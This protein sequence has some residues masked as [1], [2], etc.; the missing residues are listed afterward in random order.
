MALIAVRGAFAFAFF[1]FSLLAVAAESENPGVEIKPCDEP[2]KTTGFLPFGRTALSEGSSSFSFNVESLGISP[3]P[4][5]SG[6]NV[7]FI[8]SGTSN[9]STNVSTNDIIIVLNY[10]R[11]Q[12]DL[13]T[14]ETTLCR[15]LGCE[16]AKMECPLLVDSHHSF[17]L[18][19]L[20]GEVKLPG[21]EY[22]RFGVYTVRVQPWLRLQ[23]TSV[24]RLGACLQFEQIVYF[25]WTDYFSALLAFIISSAASWHIG[26][27]TPKALPLITGYLIVGV[28]L[29]PYGTNFITRYHI[30]LLGKFINSVALSFI[31]FAAGEEIFFPELKA[32]MRPI[33]SFM[34]SVASVTF[35]LVMVSFS[36]S[37]SL[38]E[39]AAEQEDSCH[40]SIGALVAVIMIARSPATAVAVAQELKQTGK[41]IKLLMGVTVMSDI[42]VLVGFGVVSAVASAACPVAGVNGYITSFDGIAVLILLGQFVAV[43]LVGLAVG[44][45]LLFVLWIPFQRIKIGN[46][47]LVYRSHLKG[48]LII[49]L[50]YFVFVALERVAE[51]TLDAWGRELVI[52]PL[53]V[54]MIAASLAGHRSSNREQFANILDKSSPYVFLPF[55]TLTGA[56]LELGKVFSMLPL[57]LFVFTIRGVAIFVSS[58]IGCKFALNE[59]K[60]DVSRFIKYFWLTL[61]SQAGVALG[62]ALEIQQR[63]P[64]WGK[65]FATL[66]LSVV[67]LNQ[68]L[69]PPLCKLG[70]LRLAPRSR[71]S[72]LGRSDR[73]RPLLMSASEEYDEEVW[74]MESPATP[75]QLNED[76]VIEVVATKEGV[77]VL[78]RSVPRESP[79]HSAWS[80]IGPH[81]ASSSSRNSRRIAEVSSR[82]FS[83]RLRGLLFGIEG[84]ENEESVSQ[85]IVDAVSVPRSPAASSGKE[86]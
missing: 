13:R 51:S 11:N 46:E 70:L 57:A 37:G 62:L 64:S 28:I 30:H 15:L 21:L 34:G 9:V 39:F 42:V 76:D 53:M 14:E 12:G 78:A 69:G 40:W 10:A 29:G 67:V 47:V 3:K 66:I 22:L 32:V 5:R 20:P 72:G 52:E 82:P 74:E 41:H 68:L 55:F 16:A 50:G 18:E 45:I 27:F 86:K 33:L 19:S 80:H 7:S 36:A 4:L 60:A 49:P 48:F 73:K 8:I 2:A 23:T 24:Q 85:M 71:T 84:E 75:R 83:E 44:G 25:A 17:L 31:S 58:A 1:I 54:C 61:L 26:K 59:S 6:K 65:E 63:Y 56:S 43:A 38:A 81:S 77:R 35:L 79:H